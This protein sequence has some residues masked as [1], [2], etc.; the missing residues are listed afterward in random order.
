M[1]RYLLREATGFALVGLFGLGGLLVGQNL[2]R[3]LLDMAS[4]GFAMGDVARLT[5]DLG[6]MLAGYALPVALLFG[7]LTALARLA[8]DREILAFRSLGVSR[9]AVLVPLLGMALV[10]SV[11]TG[12]LLDYAQPLGRR[13]IRGIFADLASRG[14]FIQAA[15]FTDLDREGS[16]VVFVDERRGRS[17]HG[18]LLSDRS[19]PERPFVVA[20]ER[21]EFLFDGTTGQATLLLEKGDVHFEMPAEQNASQRIAFGELAYRLDLSRMVGAGIQRYTASEFTSPEI[22]EILHYFDLHG[23]APEPM[24]VRT[25]HPYEIELARRSAFPWAPVVLA[26][27]AIPLATQVS[28][29]ARSMGLLL[30]IGLSFAYYV[31]LSAAAALVSSAGTPPLLAMWLPNLAFLAVA[32]WIWS[33]SDLGA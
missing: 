18:V 9:V 5:L 14:G 10:T 27:L 12:L 11:A 7:I 30:S 26:L 1:M 28:R 24:R 25:R 13:Q 21:G 3:H 16:R 4:L 17:L 2:L 23:E 31:A 6:L 33:R 19:S 22:R 32:G 8:G 29:A 15:A 20:A